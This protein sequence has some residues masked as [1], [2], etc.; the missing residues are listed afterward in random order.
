VR[1]R[2]GGW[3][4][5]ITEAHAGITEAHELGFVFYSTACLDTGG[6]LSGYCMSDMHLA[7]GYHSY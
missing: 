1:E 6:S 3:D 5:G 2:R 7:T 4:A